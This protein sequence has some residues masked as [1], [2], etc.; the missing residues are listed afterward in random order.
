MVKRFFDFVDKND[1]KSIMSKVIAEIEFYLLIIVFIAPMIR[2]FHGS[3]SDS[4]MENSWK[5][6][7]L[8]A[9]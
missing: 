3:W 6:P 8:I 5:V 7:P 1:G 4:F 2:N 9:L